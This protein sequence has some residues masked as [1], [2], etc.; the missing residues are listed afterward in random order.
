MCTVSPKKFLAF[1]CQAKAPPPQPSNPSTPDD[2]FWDRHNTEATPA[3]VN[4]RA[5]QLQPAHPSRLSPAPSASQP[6]PSSHGETP[7]SPFGQVGNQSPEQ[8]P[9]ALCQSQ[10]AQ[11]IILCHLTSSCQMICKQQQQQEQSVLALS[12]LRRVLDKRSTCCFIATA[13][14]LPVPATCFAS[15]E[16]K[17]VLP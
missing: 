8:V 6:G 13:A 4:A 12:V 5:R 9:A 16:Q 1:S 3:S 14:Y 17:H 2:G 15:T 10:S 7:Q 11:V